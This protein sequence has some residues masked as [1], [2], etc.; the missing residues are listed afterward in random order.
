MWQHDMFGLEWLL[1]TSP[2]PA[3]SP[4]CYRLNFLKTSTTF[5]ISFTMCFWVTLFSLYLPVGIF[6]FVKKKIKIYIPLTMWYLHKH[7]KLK[8]SAKW[9]EIKETAKIT[10]KVISLLKIDISSWQWVKK[11]NMNN[12]INFIGLISWSRYFLTLKRD[13]TCIF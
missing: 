2:F 6:K 12:L 5:T 13:I 3:L 8:Y 10:R 1:L 11:V 9:I 7:I 4:F